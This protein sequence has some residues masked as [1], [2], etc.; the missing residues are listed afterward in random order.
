MDRKAKARF[1]VVMALIRLGLQPVPV[2]ARN[3][4]GGYQQ[5]GSPVAGGYTIAVHA[6]GF[7]R[8]QCGSRGCVSIHVPTS[9][10][11]LLYG[12]VALNEAGVYEGGGSYRVWGTDGTDDSGRPG[13]FV[14]CGA[15]EAQ[16]VLARYGRADTL[17]IMD[18]V[19]DGSGW[20]PS[21]HGYVCVD[22]DTN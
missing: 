19:F 21:R 11:I 9:Y 18:R 5:G 3:D 6:S 4:Y 2:Q 10:D 1:L 14:S 13:L 20:V 8:Y 12:D 15:N 22:T 7:V 17:Q 16:I